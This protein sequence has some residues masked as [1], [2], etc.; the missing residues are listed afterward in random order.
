MSAPCPRRGWRRN[1]DPD[2]GSQPSPVSMQCTRF[3][4]GNT[5]VVTA[6]HFLPRNHL[7]SGRETWSAAPRTTPTPHTAL[8]QLDCEH[9][10][11]VPPHRKAPPLPPTPRD[12]PRHDRSEETSLRALGMQYYRDKCSVRAINPFRQIP[13]SF[14]PALTPIPL[15]ARMTGN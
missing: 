10:K 11:A 1:S 2:P 9:K 3:L 6:L 5:P 4:A 12:R 15:R 7:Y 13:P 8:S 14:Q